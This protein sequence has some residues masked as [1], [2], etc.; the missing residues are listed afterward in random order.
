MIWHI[1][2]FEMGSLDDE[3]RAELEEALRGLAAIEQVA[4]L[5]VS[6]DIDDPEVTG[7]ITGF[8]DR[9]DLD[10]YREH[11]DHLPVLQRMREL[12]VPAVRLDVASEDDAAD[13]P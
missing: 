5:R 3:R 1:V 6:R 12:R 13:L 8:R 2:R 11:P 7:L 9:D 10:V 4:W